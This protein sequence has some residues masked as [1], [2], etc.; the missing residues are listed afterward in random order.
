MV[1]TELGLPQISYFPISL[2]SAH[3]MKASPLIRE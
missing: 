3:I 2:N 1:L